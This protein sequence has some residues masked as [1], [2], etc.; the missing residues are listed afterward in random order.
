MKILIKKVTAPYRIN[1]GG[2][3]TNRK[4]VVFES[5]DWGSI[6]M[7]SAEVYNKLLAAGYRVDEFDYERFDSLASESDLINLFDL[8]T[9]VKD[10]SGTHP[11]FTANT[12]VANPDFKKIRES[13]FSKYYFELFTDTLNKY[14]AHKKSFKIWRHGMES[15]IFFPQFHAR[16][17]LNVSLFMEDLR[18]GNQDLRF[19]FDQ[20]FAGYVPKQGEYGENHYVE[21]LNISGEKDREAKLKILI[22]GLALFEQIFGYRSHSMIPPNYIWYP[23]YNEGISAKGIRYYQGRRKMRTK[24]PGKKE[25]RIHH[26]LGEINQFGQLYLIRNVFFEPTKCK[27]DGLKEVEKALHYISVAFKMGKPAVISTHRLN[28][29]GFIDPSNSAK[30]LNLLKTLLLKILKKWPDAEF[31]NS[32]ELGEVIREKI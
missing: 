4:I 5:D 28:Y 30:N 19:F 1:I 20:Q 11:V 23:E 21:A 24:Y 26:K 15:G 2:W 31:K 22:D 18:S 25:T 7:P 12:V 8:L 13:G 16:E 3:S 10:H 32:V 6:R 27:G 9:S 17:H 14:P 29:I